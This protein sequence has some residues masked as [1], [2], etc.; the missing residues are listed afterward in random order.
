LF[1]TL[2]KPIVKVPEIIVTFTALF[3]LVK[4]SKAVII[5]VFVLF[6]P[7]IGVIDKG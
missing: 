1:F 4:V 6:L 2:L 7:C 5:V 3:E